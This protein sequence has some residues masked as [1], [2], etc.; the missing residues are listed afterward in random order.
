MIILHDCI[1]RLTYGVTGH[2]LSGITESAVHSTP[3]GLLTP[4]LNLNGTFYNF[5][6]ILFEGCQPIE[7]ILFTKLVMNHT[8]HVVSIC[9]FVSE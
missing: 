8:T 2:S 1:G 6:F 7:H 9:C 3:L 5:Y 4:C